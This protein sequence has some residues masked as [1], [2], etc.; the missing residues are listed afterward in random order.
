MVG[1]ATAW[2]LQERGRSVTVLERRHVAAGASWGNAGWVTPSLTTPLPEPGMLRSGMRALLDSRAPLYVPLTVGLQLLRFL[3][4]FLRN[5][6]VRRWRVAMRSYLP[7]NR[8]AVEAFEAL[9]AG[10]VQAKMREAEPF[11]ICFAA[12]PIATEDQEVRRH[13]GGR[14]RGR[15]RRT[16]RSRGSGP[17]AHAV[18]ECPGG[19]PV[20]PAAIH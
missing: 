8:R 16:D 7:V 5:S 18:V 9:S 3:A 13:P 20:A 14:S 10:G 17:R 1:L 2:F 6:T 12:A 19:C 11:L 15:F 4:S